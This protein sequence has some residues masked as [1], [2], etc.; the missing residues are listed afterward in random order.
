MPG[1]AVSPPVPLDGVMMRM[2]AG[3]T[4]DGKPA[5]AGW[6][7][8]SCGVVALA[9]AEG[10]MPGAGTSGASRSGAGRASG[11]GR[12]RGA[13]LAGT[14][15]RPEACGGRRRREGQPGLP[16]ITGPRRDPGGLP[17]LGPASGRRGRRGPPD[18]FRI[19]GGR[20][21]DPGDGGDEALGTGP[22]PRRRPGRA[23]LPVV[24]GSGRHH[25]AWAAPVPGTGRHG[26]WKPP[27]CANDN[28]PVARVALAA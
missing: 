1:G 11:R 3:A 6:R 27:G 2:N 26:G 14:Q 25:R 5:D 16:G 4:E 24:P 15:P 12:G 10:S 28:R 9:G 13:P 8:A 20:E 23:D 7:G 19:R 21:Q 18:R 22:G 17:A